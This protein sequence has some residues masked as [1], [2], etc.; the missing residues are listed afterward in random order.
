[1]NELARLKEEVFDTGQR[2]SADFSPGVSSINLSRGHLGT[3]TSASQID[4]AAQVVT[5]L[6]IQ[7]T[8]V[9]N[10]HVI[11]LFE[12]SL[13]CNDNIQI[14][15]LFQPQGNKWAEVAR[16]RLKYNE[17]IQ[18]VTSLQQQLADVEDQISPAQNESDKDR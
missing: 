18:Q 4:T 14:C 8:M 7:V 6:L 17:A 11:F 2:N 1:M 5:V 10:V 9:F 15:Q 13:L 3:A 12:Y 16:M